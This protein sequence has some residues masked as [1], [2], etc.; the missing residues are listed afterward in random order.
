VITE[1]GFA[2]V[3]LWSWPGDG[4]NDTPE[5]LTTTPAVYDTLK[6]C[7]QASQRD[8]QQF[9]VELQQDLGYPGRGRAVCKPVF[10]FNRKEMK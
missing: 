4:P 2:V 8:F 7:N 6:E 1:I 9:E 3:I 10:E 5:I